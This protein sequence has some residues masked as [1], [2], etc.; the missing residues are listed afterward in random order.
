MQKNYKY[1]IKNV[2]IL[3]IGNFTTKLLSLFLIPLYTAVLSTT[4][5]GEYDLLN[6]TIGLLVPVFTL[7]IFEGIFRYALDKDIDKGN[8]LGIAFK[9]FFLSFIPL[10]VLI[11]INSI[12]DWIP[13][14][15]NYV[16]FFILMYAFNALSA[17]LVS[18]AKGLEN[19]KIVAFSGVI[20]SLVIIVSNILFLLVF[21]FGLTGYFVANIL[22]T[23]IQCLCILIGVRLWKYNSKVFCRNNSRKELE[24]K[25]ITYS[26]PL[27]ANSIGWWINN[28]S[29]RFIVTFFC[30][31]STNGIY[32]I[33]YKIPTFL[34]VI[35][36]IFNQAWNL[37]A[38]KDFDSDDKDGFFSKT[39]SIYNCL[40]IFVCS[41]L[42]LGNKV[43][44]RVFYS[45]NFYIA[46]KYVPFLLIAFYFGALSGYIGAIFAAVNRTEIYAKSTV[47]GAIINTVLNLI[48]V[49]FIGAMGAAIAT[50]I[51]YFVVWLIRFYYMS[52]FIHIRINVK[53]DILAYIIILVQAV[54][55]IV[56]ENML[57]MY[58]F[59]IILFL[60]MIL[61]YVKDMKNAFK[62]I[63]AKL[64]GKA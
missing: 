53:R 17:I 3:A 39:Y 27:I 18:V 33:A 30:G 4:E 41:M 36:S 19:L 26:K 42:I 57:Y 61:L 37:S 28:V 34:N 1:L 11:V 58:L 43:L 60:V 55:M 45:N 40:M 63:V 7:N 20:S 10:G 56:V 24:K 59:Q 13:T 51:S 22:G 9:Y 32:S 12:F 2:G 44:A 25:V 29:D 50:L 46:W 35:V 21:K 38:I 62:V 31:L 16:L 23:A 47:I 64:R 5:Y 6:T 49:Y 52:K 48:L 14:F 54:A 15:N 8:L